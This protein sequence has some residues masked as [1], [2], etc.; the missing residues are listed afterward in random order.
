[1]GN[2]RVTR[3]VAAPREQVWA[4]YTD[5]VSWQDWSGIGRV[6][7]ERRGAP[8]PNGVGCVRVISS[9]GVSVHEEI[10]SFDPPS[11]MTYRVIRGGIPIKNHL[12]EVVFDEDPASDA[13]TVL[14]WS[15]RF[16]SKIPGFDFLWCR[17][18]EKVF[19]DTLDAMIRN[20]FPASLGGVG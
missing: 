9:Y 10:L 6:R 1:M 2:V 19:R 14:T 17:I 18:V 7:L 15:C 16:D 3:K 20:R 4:V 11:R 12:G 5:H 8:T 13:T